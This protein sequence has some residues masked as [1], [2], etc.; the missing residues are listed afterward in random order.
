[1]RITH[2]THNAYV[3]HNAHVTN[4]RGGTDGTDGLVITHHAS[5][6][7]TV[8]LHATQFTVLDYMATPMPTVKEGRDREA[9]GP[10]SCVQYSRHKQTVDDLARELHGS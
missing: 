5:T 10:Y 2:I 8:W 7:F 4:G 9:N 6:D 3:T 1:M